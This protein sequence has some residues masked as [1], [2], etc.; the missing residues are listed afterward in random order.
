MSR[1]PRDEIFSNF[2]KWD[3]LQKRSDLFRIYEIEILEKDD[4]WRNFDEI[5][6]LF[7]ERSKKFRLPMVLEE[8]TELWKSDA[9]FGRQRLRGCN[10]K[11]L[12]L[13]KE[14]PENFGVTGDFVNE[15]LG[16]EMNLE[17]ALEKN[18]IFIVNH[19]IMDEILD[20]ECNQ[21]IPSPMTLFY[22]NKEDN[23]MPIAIQLYQQKGDHNPVF[24]PNDSHY[25]WMLVKMWF[26]NAD[27]TYQRMLLMT[28]SHW[29]LECITVSLHRNLSPSHP[30]H[31][32]LQT[33]LGLVLTINNFEMHALLNGHSNSW[34]DQNM[35]IKNEGMLK[36][37]ER[38]WKKFDFTKDILENS[39]EDRQVLSEEIL[40]EYP[41]RDDALVLKQ[42]I[43]DYVSQIVKGYYENE[44]T[45]VGDIEIQNWAGEMAQTESCHLKN[46]PGN[47]EFA[48]FEDFI[49][50]LSHVIFKVTV[51]HAALNLPLYDECAFV[52][53]Y[54]MCMR[55]SPPNSKESLTEA[56]VMAALPS[57]NTTM[58]ILII[59]K[60]LSERDS[61]GL[62]DSRA[63]FQ[64]DPISLPAR[65]RFSG[66]LRESAAMIDIRNK[67]ERL[68]KGLVYDYLNPKG[69]T[70][71]KSL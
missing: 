69:G 14:I 31:R 70:D 25:T 42:N 1:L 66:Q 71:K 12:Q 49:Q 50:F 19:S 13:C 58:E 65:E 68:E 47:G 41:Y 21:V 39:M 36:L 24:T 63:Q 35:T 38:Y 20:N 46:L 29:I 22:L 43:Q 26:N 54:P 30:I 52:P 60:L 15:L 2:Y 23:L 6:G 44:E 10:P 51:E 45:L 33:Y 57:K 40:K 7:T 8:G 61:S 5:V 56:D 11:S 53:N 17:E 16:D 3:I 64:Y 37:I 28:S 48:A 4:S 59:N 34:I 62:A 9:H 18:R 67:K 55:G 32:L 27:A